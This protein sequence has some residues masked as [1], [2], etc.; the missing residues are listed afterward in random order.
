MSKATNIRESGETVWKMAEESCYLPTEINT[1]ENGR[2]VK[3]MGMVFS[4][5]QADQHMK[6]TG[7]IAKEQ[8]KES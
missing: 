7:K 3:R 1:M 6:A 5:I 2:M 8:V 4:Q